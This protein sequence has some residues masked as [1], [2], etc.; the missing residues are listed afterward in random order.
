[1]SLF[2][3]YLRMIVGR[4]GGRLEDGPELD[5]LGLGRMESKRKEWDL[6]VE[7]LKGFGWEKL[8]SEAFVQE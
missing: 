1:M 7:R 2:S 5:F 6:L 8:L 4:L 3:H